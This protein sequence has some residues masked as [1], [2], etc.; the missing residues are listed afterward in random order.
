MSGVSGRVIVVGSVNVDLSMLVERLPRPGETVSGGR[1]TRSQGGKSANQAVAAARSG[2]TTAFVGAV[3]DDEL[4]HAA[5]AVLADEGIDVSEL[6]TLP[7]E[8]TGVAVILVDVD[9]ENCISVASGANA[10]MSPA[11]T[12]DALSRISPTAADVILVSN[13]IFVETKGVALC[14]GAAA[15]ATTIL[16]PAPATGLS[17]AILGLVDILTPNE[18]ELATLAMADSSSDRIEAAARR[19]VAKLA[20][21]GMVL[22]TL[23]ERGALL[24]GPGQSKEIPVLPVTVAD[25][26]G[27]GDAFN[28]TLAAEIARGSEVSAAAERSVVAAGLA[29]TRYGSRAGMPT[30]AELDHAVAGYRLTLEATAE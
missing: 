16:N 3:G 25:T 26:V 4:G 24:I 20:P 22:V 19:L 1:L 30:M 8:D 6:I 15:A 7:G 11:Y 27:A 13:E 21:G 10:A 17:S 12:G 14:G 18:G 23:G 9:G 29:T 5:R 28:G 2:A